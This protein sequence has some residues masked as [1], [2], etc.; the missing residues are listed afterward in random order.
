MFPH[1]RLA[2]PLGLPS[3]SLSL[4]NYTKLLCVRV[5]VCVCVCVCACV[6][7][8]SYACSFFLGRS[9]VF[10]C[11]SDFV[12]S[13]LLLPHK[14]CARE[15]IEVFYGVIPGRNSAR[16]VATATT[17]RDHLLGQP[18]LPSDVCCVQ[19]MLM[20]FHSLASRPLGGF[21]QTPGPTVK[22]ITLRWVG[23]VWVGWRKVR[24]CVLKGSKE[25]TYIRICSLTL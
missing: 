7:C 3:F 1:N 2:W 8:C 21:C 20:G 18:T 12:F 9:P 22:Q 19:T 23:S 4:L 17:Y 6:F 16:S 14:L 15:T 5:Y 24:V 25:K 13:W 11:L 10:W